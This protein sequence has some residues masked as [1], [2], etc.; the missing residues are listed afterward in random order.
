LI[1]RHPIGRK[2]PFASKEPRPIASVEQLYQEFRRNRHDSSVDYASI[3][4]GL[5]I[6]PAALAQMS[7][8]DSVA[9][10]AAATA[11]KDALAEEPTTTPVVVSNWP[12]GVPCSALH[13]NQDGSWT[14]IDVV[15]GGMHLQN[16]TLKGTPE[17]STFDQ[18]CSAAAQK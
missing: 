4:I 10:P 3:A 16:D 13:K 7:H 2:H 9:G 15:V 18:K 11:S 8:P 14:V 17:T 6:A 12:D 5:L 1:A